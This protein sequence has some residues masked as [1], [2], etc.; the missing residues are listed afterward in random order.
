M[1]RNNGSWRVALAAVAL[2]ITGGCATQASMQSSAA[3]NEPGW[4]VLIDN[5]RGLE[6]FIG[7]GGA[8]WREEGGA[9]VAD[10]GKDG[11]IFTKKSYKDFRI[12]AEF[13]ADT[14]TNSGIFV[15]MTDRGAIG[16]ATSYEINIFDQRPE[17]KYG[18]GAIVNVA[19][20]DP[21]PKAGGQWNTYDITVQ[22][23]RMIVVLNGQKT[24]DV[25][26]RRFLAAGPFALQ[27]ASGANNAPGGP[28]K[29]RNLRVKPL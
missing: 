26:D 10:K 18:T 2:A 28:I 9:I 8:N 25:E 1:G 13:W 23:P 20:V 17:Q 16:S 29:W 15:R 27:Y 21:M 14:T 11:F 6:N 7:I 4:E 24:A 3:V 19:A 12:V 5:G 22:G